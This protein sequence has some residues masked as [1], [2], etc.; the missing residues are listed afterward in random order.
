MPDGGSRARPASLDAA[1]SFAL[2]V[3]P[4]DVAHKLVGTRSGG[5]RVRFSGMGVT[6]GMLS[7]SSL[8]LFRIGNSM[9]TA[10]PQPAR[11]LAN[12]RRP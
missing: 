7:T 2:R 1:R 5:R 3:A 11:R 12:R 9:A 4:K 6:V 10:T 8:S